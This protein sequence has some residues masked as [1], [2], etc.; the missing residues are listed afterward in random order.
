V[1][2]NDHA[3]LEGIVI[4]EQPKPESTSP[5]PPASTRS[6]LG[7]EVP[8]FH[9]VNQDGRPIHLGQYRGKTLLLT[10][11]YTRC[12]LPDYCPLMSKNFTHVMEAMRSDMALTTAT[13]LLSIS[14]DPDH[15]KPSVLRSYG[16]AYIDKT[17]ANPFQ[18]WEFASGTSEQVRAVAQFF[19]LSYSTEQGQIVHSLVTALV[20]P[21]GK[22]RKL[23]RGNEWKPAEVVADLRGLK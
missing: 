11:I 9:L 4:T 19:G 10:F 22:V 14:I 21:D 2:D 13:H 3:W 23:Y 15:D 18:R 20:G 16:R 8:D 12:P 6:P 17:S 7:A 5:A 1:V